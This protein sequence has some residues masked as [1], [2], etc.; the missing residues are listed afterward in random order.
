MERDKLFILAAPFEDGPGKMWFCRDCAMIEGALLANPQWAERI[1][2]RRIPFPRPRP[3]VAALLGEELQGLPVIVLAETSP[4][5][6]RV[7]RHEG[8]AYI[9]DASMIT[10]YLARTYGG[11]APHP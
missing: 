1:D 9:K 3:E 2:V 10:D 7:R 8:R 5:P 6:D 11:A 4:A